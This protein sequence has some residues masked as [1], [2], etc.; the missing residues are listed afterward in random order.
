MASHTGAFAHCDNIAI[1]M[2]AMRTVQTS[3]ALSSNAKHR[4]AISIYFPE[5]NFYTK[6]V[7]SPVP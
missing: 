6:I 3:L 7:L 2:A 4:A 5:R 1:V